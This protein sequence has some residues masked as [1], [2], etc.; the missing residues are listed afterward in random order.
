MITYNT[1]K[2]ISERWNTKLSDSTNFNNTSLLENEILEYKS[3]KPKKSKSIVLIISIIFFTLSFLISCLQFSIDFRL[4]SQTNDA[5]YATGYVAGEII[6]TLAIIVALF[7]L[8]TK[9]IKKKVVTLIF[10]IFYLLVSLS[11]TTLA[12]ENSLNQTKMNNAAKDKFISLCTDISKNNN[13]ENENFDKSVYGNMT[14][15]LSYVKD[16]G[17][18]LKKIQNDFVQDIDS[19]DCDNILNLA[20]LSSADN[21][22]NS[23]KKIATYL[24]ALNKYEAQHNNLVTDMGNNIPTLELPQSFKIN[25]L[26]GFKESQEENGSLISDLFKVERENYTKINELMDFLLSIQGKYTVSGEK[27]IFKSSDDINKYNGYIKDIKEFNQKKEDLNNTEHKKRKEILDKL[28]Q[29][30]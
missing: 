9:V 16:Y 4:K 27:I 8:S 13:I 28:K 6:F 17:I 21:I 1:C 23:K 20:N 25:I 18:K 14:P 5:S 26:E 24:E 10:S 3:N 15:L 22:N 2:I 12:I 11:T 29:F 7:V 19:L 30:K